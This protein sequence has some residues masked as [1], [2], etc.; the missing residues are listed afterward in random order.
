MTGA[1]AAVAPFESVTV[2][3]IEVPAAM[4][5]VQVNCVAEVGCES[6]VASGLYRVGQGRMSRRSGAAEAEKQLVTHVPE[7]WPP[8]RTRT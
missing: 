4:L 2:R 5:T 7:S 3:V 8:G 6:R 1:V